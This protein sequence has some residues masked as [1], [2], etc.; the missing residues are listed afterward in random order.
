ML[1]CGERPVRVETDQAKAHKDFES[2][3]LGGDARKGLMSLC[4]KVCDCPGFGRPLLETARPK[5][6]FVA[7][8][9][10]I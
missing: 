5:R 6:A 10:Q 1:V 7:Y 8:L 4:T 3:M 2:H 9:L